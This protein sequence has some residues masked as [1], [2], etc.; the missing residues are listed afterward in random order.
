MAADALVS[1]SLWERCLA[2]VATF[3]PRVSWS[4]GESRGVSGSL[5]NHNRNFTKQRAA[6]TGPPPSNSLSSPSG[7]PATLPDLAVAQISPSVTGLLTFAFQ[8]SD[9]GRLP[10]QT[11]LGPNFSITTCLNTKTKCLLFH[12]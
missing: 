6:A 3:R 9:A 5:G 2:A 7:I 11:R 12:S 10:E 1:W 8:G 4:L